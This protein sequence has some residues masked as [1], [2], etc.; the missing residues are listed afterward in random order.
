MFLATRPSPEQVAAFLE[1][2]RDVALVVPTDWSRGRR[3]SGFLGG[4][5]DDHGRTWPRGVGAGQPR[6][7]ALGAFRA[8]L[9]GGSPPSAP[10]TIGTTVCVLV[11]HLGFWSMNGCRVVSPDRRPRRTR[12]RI[13]VRHADQSRR[14]RRGDLQADARSGHWRGRLHD[15]C[16]V[17]ACAFARLGY[18]VTR[19]LQARF[20]RDSAAAM[21]R[22]CRS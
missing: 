22:A 13:C 4:P 15:P 9:G 10:L 19:R 12:D 21:V 18:P 1:Q 7:R 20:R 2:S 6:T 5:A 16:G 11:R 17:A 8:R 3:A 14:V